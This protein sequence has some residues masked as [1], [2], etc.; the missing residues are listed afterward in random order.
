MD[1][2]VNLSD[3]I[4][5]DRDKSS[6][7]FPFVKPVQVLNRQLKLKCRNPLHPNGGTLS[8][9]REAANGQVYHKPRTSRFRIVRSD[10]S[11]EVLEDAAGLPEADTAAVGLC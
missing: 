2:V 1:G 3:S 9:Y 5:E 10:G 6:Y 7:L 11:A 4:R 8:T